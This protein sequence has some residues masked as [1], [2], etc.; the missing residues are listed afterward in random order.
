[1]DNFQYSVQLSDQDW[2][3]FS[4]TADECGLLQ[5]GLASG[6]ELFSSDID[7]GDSSGSSPPGPQPLLTGQLAAQG[8]GWK[9][10]EE[11][12][13]VATW[14]PASG[15]QW[16]PVLALGA[17]QQGAG[18]SARPEALLSV[19][20]GTALPDQCSSFPGSVDSSGEMQRLLQ[21]PS[22]SPSG[23]P[24]PSSNP[25]SHTA[26]PQKSPNSSDTP[27]R[28]TDRKKRRPAGAKGGRHS[29]TPGPAAA[30]TGSPKL[31]EARAEESLGLAGARGKGFGAGT[32]KA[33]AGAQQN[34]PQPNSAGALSTSVPITEQGTDQI[35]M[36]PRAEL[37]RASRPVQEAHPDASM[38]EPDE[39]LSMPSSKPQPDVAL[40]TPDSTP[41]LHVDLLK[42]GPMAKPKV[43]SPLPVS[44]AVP[45]RALP[46]SASKTEPAV[47]AS[48]P[49]PG[50]EAAAPSQHPVLQTRAGLIETQTTVPPRGHQ[51][52][53]GG[54]PGHALGEP[55]L[56]P[57]QA[58]KK[59]KVRFSMAV[60][61][62]EEPGSKEAT[63]PPSSASAWP[64]TP[65]MAVRGREGSATW[66]AVVVGPR[67]P[68]P[69]ILKHLPPPAPSASAGTGPGSCFAVTLPEAYEFFFCDTIEEEE[70][71]EEDASEEAVASQALGDVQWPDI[72]EFFFQDCHTQRLGHQG[73]C[74]PTPPP[75][76]DA[77]AAV[78]PG[79]PVPFSIPE[80]YEH[81]LGED[82]CGGE[83]LP[84]P[85]L[86]LQTSEPLR[87][88]GTRT[89]P[90]PGPARAEQLSLAAKQAGELRR[91]R[92]SL[93]F[94]Q[95]DM[96][97]VFVALATWAVRTSDL[98]TPDAWKTVLLAN[99][100]TISAIRYFRR[101]V[102]RGR[103]SS[104]SPS[105]SPSPSY[106]S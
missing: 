60:P 88:I 15:S 13:S 84:T 33:M 54:A 76:A 59:K 74:S 78:P 83:V 45:S 4:A 72:C 85:L 86:Q 5:A 6:D 99:I 47:A 35:R 22:S 53:P 46:H 77:A 79:N 34:K 12:H 105:P 63:G 103:S 55:P 65:G 50:T 64:S 89:P 67:P 3:E 28:S 32:A 27:L 21:G 90:E 101:E 91:P 36:T 11:E 96:C 61:S 70:E 100:G 18:T 24:P 7:Q 66:D 42:A 87:N 37:H 94:S 102:R 69:R 8:K 16:Q 49:V 62:P 92:A 97:L 23:E 1:M 73:S 82:R 30:P 98:Q 17:S 29:D 81:F 57:A 95:N 71:E 19:S 39:A 40:S 68:Q 58:P 9:A 25:P 44:V 75:G 52:K 26:I 43:D 10:C 14:Q 48:T 106:S 104:P 51:E 31:P 80:A 20:S 93:T 38:A 56:G 2:A 41:G